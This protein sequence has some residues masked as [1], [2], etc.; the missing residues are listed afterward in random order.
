MA[1]SFAILSSAVISDSP[2]FTKNMSTKAAMKKNEHTKNNV[3][4][5]SKSINE[6]TM[7]GPSIAAKKFLKDCTKMFALK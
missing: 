4:F 2:L 1:F 5:P 6:P 3:T 7:K